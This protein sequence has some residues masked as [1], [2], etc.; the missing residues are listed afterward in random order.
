ML[1]ERHEVNERW[2]QIWFKKDAKTV[3][4]LMADDFMS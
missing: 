1:S 2:N 4:R 3:D